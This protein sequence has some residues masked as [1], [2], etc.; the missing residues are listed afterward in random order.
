MPFVQHKS[1]RTSRALVQNRIE[2]P[3]N[4][5]RRSVIVPKQRCSSWRFRF[6]TL[7][8]A[9]HRAS[10]MRVTSSARRRIPVEAPLKGGTLCRLTSL[11]LRIPSRNDLRPA[12][13]RKGHWSTLRID[14][15]A[16]PRVAKNNHHDVF[17]LWKIMSKS[18]T[19]GFIPLKAGYFLCSLEPKCFFFLS[20]SLF[21]D[22]R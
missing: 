8:C 13:F 22:I 5:G 16:S 3:R 1:S 20:L 19:W 21:R 2:S 15:F 6:P 12:L 4:P 18:V 17:A 11:S 7:A 9:A 10:S 14:V